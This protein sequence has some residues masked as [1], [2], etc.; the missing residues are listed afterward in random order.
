[1]PSRPRTK[2][3]P[4]NVK[5]DKNS[6]QRTKGQDKRYW[7]PRW[8]KLR[9]EIL[10]EQDYTCQECLKNGRVKHGKVC[11]HIDIKRKIIDFYDRTNLQ[12]LCDRCHNRKSAQERHL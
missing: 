4:W 1:M 10:K 5:A 11:D 9:I 2:Q 7:S 6:F 8:R 3:R 12:V